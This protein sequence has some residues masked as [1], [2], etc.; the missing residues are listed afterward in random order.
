MHT[1][2]QQGI[3]MFFGKKK[4]VSITVEVK[5]SFLE[6]LKKDR[7]LGPWSERSGEV[8]K[9]W[10]DNFCEIIAKIVV[11]VEDDPDKLNQF[12]SK[13]SYGYM[14]PYQLIHNK[15][16]SNEQLLPLLKTYSPVV[17]AVKETLEEQKDKM[18]D[19]KII[20]KMTELHLQ[21]LGKDGKD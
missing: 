3:I 8:A 2:L 4:T 21:D 10:D 7:R 6:I 16:I 13:L 20:K 18:S 12:E 15:S 19:I 9:Y 17:F 14:E 1:F 11:L 5:E